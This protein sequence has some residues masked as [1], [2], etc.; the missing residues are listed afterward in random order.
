MDSVEDYL[1]FSVAF[2]PVRDL[3][4]DWDK[5]DEYKARCIWG[6]I[7]T[8]VAFAQ[9]VGSF[10][11][12][13]ERDILFEM[14]YKQ[15]PAMFLLLGLTIV[16][17]FFLVA[18][19]QFSLLSPEETFVNEMN[20]YLRCEIDVENI[21]FNCTPSARLRILKYPSSRVVVAP[22]S[23]GSA[24]DV[25]SLRVGMETLMSTRSDANV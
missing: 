22:S 21:S 25:E 19:G 10:P 1:T 12:R 15:E 20:N 3:L 2:L 18:A 11:A 14:L 23:M 4:Y 17:K 6:Y 8:C 7:H 13:E 9:V 16:E 5:S 24:V